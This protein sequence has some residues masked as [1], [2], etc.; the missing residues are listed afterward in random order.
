[1]AEDDLTLRMRAAGAR[2]ASRDTDRFGKSVRGVG[3]SAEKASKKSFRL[4]GAMGI[5][6][7]RM[8][9]SISLMSDS[10]QALQ[11]LAVVGV[12]A[13][14][15]KSASDLNEEV[16]K[17]GVVF[18]R[19]S[20][21]MLSWSRTASD[22][23]GQSQQQALEA[24]GVFGNMLVPMGS[25]RKEAAKMSRR[26]ITLASDMAS[27]NNADPSEVL[28][29]LR[30][31]LAGESEPLRRYGVF[32]ND[33]RLRQ[34]ALSQG[35][36]VGKGPLDAHT[37]AMATYGLIL[38]DTKDAQGDFSRTSGGLAN[39]QRTLRAQVTDLAAQIGTALLP[40]VVTTVRW[41]VQLVKGMKNGTGEGGRLRE[42]IENLGEA[43]SN[44]WNWIKKN[45]VAL[46]AL[47]GSVLAGVVAFR[48][49]MVL[50]RI[51]KFIQVLRVLYIGWRAGVLGMTMAQL[52]L[53]FALAAN[54]VGIVVIALAALAAGLFILWKRS[55]TFREKVTA[56]WEVLKQAPS[57]IWDAVKSGLVSTLNWIIDRVNSFIG[58]INK[59]PGVDI[60]Q[61]GHVGG[62]P[63]S[64][65]GPSGPGYAPGSYGTP[66]RGRA[67]R[68]GIVSRGGEIEVGERGRER[69]QAPAGTVIRPQTS[70]RLELVGPII[71]MMP[72]GEVLAR[73]NIRVGMKRKAS[74]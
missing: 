41:I 71:L 13:F 69:V 52:G 28:D 48:A 15:V 70:E 37:K 12:G 17:T 59:I 56:V 27:F 51:I 18:G 43:L 26:M 35:L 19:S 49:L 63:T 67:A 16:S 22:S 64:P 32:L 46:T 39:M 21:E 73:Q 61:I 24:A 4:S 65:S 40:H 60:G 53:N 36:K 2:S 47:V 55:D 25:T 66:G 1:M 74:R 3:D 34:E 54:P 33:A 9:S 11:A 58:V 23:F 20:S 8:R 62:E 29:A 42:R 10:V 44:G 50:Q 38:K 6:S 72:N 14:A 57:G 7:G 30:A 31:G 5:L 45:N 68:G